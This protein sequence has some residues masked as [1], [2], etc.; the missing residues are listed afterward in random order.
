MDIDLQDVFDTIMQSVERGLPFPGD[1][2]ANDQD[3][4][5]EVRFT[6]FKLHGPATTFW[7]Y[8]V[9]WWGT[10]ACIFPCL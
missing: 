1:L 3:H 6:G 10:S 7:I 9:R 4:D 2:D 8:W 5:K